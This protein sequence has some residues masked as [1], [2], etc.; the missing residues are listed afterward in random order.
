MISRFS[1]MFLAAV[2]KFQ[3]QLNTLS[4]SGEA[5]LGDR[6]LIMSEGGI[7]NL[8]ARRE[9]IRL[10]TDCRI[11]GELLVH[12]NSGRIE[13]GDLLYI[14]PTSSIWSGDDAGVRIGHRV[15][16]SSGVMIHDTNSHPLDAAQRAEQTRMILTR[17]HPEHHFDIRSSPIVIGNDVWIGARAYIG[18]GV[19][20]GDRAIIG[21]N[22]MIL[23][24]VADDT[25]IGAGCVV[26]KEKA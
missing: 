7:V 1:K 25:I 6:S 8:S 20:I 14:G 19:K 24:D 4:A 5:F 12:R 16:I 22:A 10:G 17:G 15:L 3:S 9:N 11:R 13:A 2:R 21:A 26:R 18:K 23:A